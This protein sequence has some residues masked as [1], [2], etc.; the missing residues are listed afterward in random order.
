MTEFSVDAPSNDPGPDPRRHQAPHDDWAAPSP[1]SP[2]AGPD[3]ESVLSQALRALAGGERDL[4]RDDRSGGESDGAGGGGSGTDRGE[5]SASPVGAAP[6]SGGSSARGTTSRSAGAGTS[7][8]M[9]AAGVG[10]G[11]TVAQILLIAAII[12]MIVG[13]AAGLTFVI[14]H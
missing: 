8:S 14:V 1:D 10:S 7:A 6:G 9:G 3:P 12:G 4:P 2:Q 11:L 5:P 13:I